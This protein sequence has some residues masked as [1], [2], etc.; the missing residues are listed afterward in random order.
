[1]LEAGLEVFLFLLSLGLLIDFRVLWEVIHTVMRSFDG[2]TCLINFIT[3]R[4]GTVSAWNIFVIMYKRV[5]RQT[6]SNKRDQIG[7]A[8]RD[9]LN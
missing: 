5:W 3:I 8:N 6:S 9:P 7:E 2:D 1:M 4:V